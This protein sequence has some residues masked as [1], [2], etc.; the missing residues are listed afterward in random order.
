VNE[1]ILIGIVSF[2]DSSGCA[3]PDYPGVYTRVSAYVT[4]IQ[5]MICQNSKYKPSTCNNVNP[6]TP[7][8]EPKPT[9]KPTRKRT[10]LPTYPPTE[11]PSEAPVIRPNQSPVATM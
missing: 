2:G 1:D 4:W 7:T 5:V 3:K 8:S 9:K 11:K 10:P 6:P